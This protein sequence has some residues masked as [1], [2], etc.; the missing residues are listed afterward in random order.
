MIPKIDSPITMKD[1][2]PISLCNVLYKILAKMLAN[3][4]KK[5]LPKCIS[6]E[7]ST[8]VEGRSIL[9]NVLVAFEIIHHM[10]CKIK[11]LEGR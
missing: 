4:L 11:V 1:M 10:K 6:E 2:I 7:Q 9:D 3:M 8:F 5:V